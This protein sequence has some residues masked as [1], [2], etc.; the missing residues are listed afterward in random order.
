MNFWKALTS[1]RYWSLLP[2]L[3]LLQRLHQAFTA[4]YQDWGQFALDVSSVVY[5]G[6]DLATGGRASRVVNQQR[7]MDAVAKLSDAAVALFALIA[8]IRN[9]TEPLGTPPPA[10]RR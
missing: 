8:D 10:R 3:P 1:F 9:G 4:A 6:F 7:V 2:Y 5:D